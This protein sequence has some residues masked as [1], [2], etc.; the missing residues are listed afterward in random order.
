MHILKKIVICFCHLFY[1]MA[2]FFVFLLPSFPALSFAFLLHA[3][4]HSLTYSPLFQN[5][6]FFT[7]NSILFFLKLIF[8]IEKYNEKL[9]I[10]PALA[11]NYNEQTAYCLWSF[12]YKENPCCLIQQRGQ[13]YLMCVVW[14]PLQALGRKSCILLSCNTQ[15]DLPLGICLAMQRTHV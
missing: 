1:A 8:N 7:K 13:Q 10:V 2:L 3:F 5:F 11:I 9:P 15:R 4:F 12:L 6:S 14:G